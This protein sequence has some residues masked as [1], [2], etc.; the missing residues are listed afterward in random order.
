MYADDKEKILTKMYGNELVKEVPIKYFAM[1]IS[2]FEEAIEEVEQEEQNGN[3][4]LQ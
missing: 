1:V 2:A 4:K 3:T